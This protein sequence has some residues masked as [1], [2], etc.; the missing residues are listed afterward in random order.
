MNI[1]NI[2]L[3]IFLFGSIIFLPISVILIL[4]YNTIVKKK[5]NKLDM[6]INNDNVKAFIK[7]IKFG[8]FLK[9]DK[10]FDSLKSTYKKVKKNR[11]VNKNL[12]NEL[13]NVLLKK[14]CSKK[15]LK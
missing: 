11:N 15:D 14:G 10:I 3:V 2:V 5:Q 1:V 6:N 7:V 13:Y 12:K 9:N 4:I 8:P